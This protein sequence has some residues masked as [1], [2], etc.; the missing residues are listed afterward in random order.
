MVS[1]P[2]MT[3]AYTRT[4]DSL[5]FRMAIIPKMKA[6]ML[7]ENTSGTVTSHQRPSNESTPSPLTRIIEKTIADRKKAFNPTDHFP[8]FVR[9]SSFI[10][11]A[12]PQESRW[13]LSR[14][15]FMNEFFQMEAVA[16]NDASAIGTDP[17]CR[18]SGS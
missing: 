12:P 2:I 3:E 6:E 13:V 14:A 15:H 11:S 8:D 17:F 9:G 1:K 10:R 7:A 16:S 4:E 5:F 18:L